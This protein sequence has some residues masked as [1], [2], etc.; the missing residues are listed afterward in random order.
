MGNNIRIK[1][2]GR[3]MRP[4]FSDGDIVIIKKVEFSKIKTNDIVTVKKN[5]NFFTHR[6]IYKSLHTSEKNGRSYIITKGDRNIWSDGKIY[7]AQIIGKVEK[8]ERDGEILKPGD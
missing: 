4:F 1:T 2:F 3:S 7:P 6:V 5:K 8:I